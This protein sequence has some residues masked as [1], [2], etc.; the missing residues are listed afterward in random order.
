M[1]AVLNP[2]VFHGLRD[3]IWVDTDGI[4]PQRHEP[5]AELDATR[6]AVDL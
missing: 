5:V 6:R 2:R 1:D 4:D 3:V